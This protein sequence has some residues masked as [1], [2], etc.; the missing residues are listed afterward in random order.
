MT[1]KMKKP[2]VSILTPTKNS[3]RTIRKHLES[4]KKQS[5]KNIEIIVVDNYSQD[6]TI[7]IAKD[8]TKK[9]YQHGPE[10]SAQRNFAAKKAKGKFYLIIDSDMMLEKNV[11]SEC[12]N[13]VSNDLRIKAVIISE[14]T[15]GEGFWAKCKILE[16]NCYFGDET[17]EAAR[18][19]DKK[20]FWEM[21]GYD[22]SMTGPEDWDLPQ[23]IRIKYKIG[24]IKSIILHNEGRITLI[25]L[26]KKKYYYAKKLSKYLKKHPIN[27]TGKQLIY[28]LRPAFYK[29]WKKIIKN[30]FIAFGMIIMLMLEQLAGFMGFIFANFFTIKKK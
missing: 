19:F 29:N 4:L 30:P 1:S 23:R 26:M 6:K 21:D 22:E 20:I 25:G 27:I 15:L 28:F 9:I 17:I 14:K 12:V 5:Y 3:S 2:L 18:F 10:R 16:R 11:I 8:Y 13:L 7:E 24:R